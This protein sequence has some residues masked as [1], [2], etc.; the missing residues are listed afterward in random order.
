M[1]RP[2][3]KIT[4]TKENGKEYIFDYCNDIE[5][6]S[7]VKELSTKAKITLPR[8]FSFQGNVISG[9][10]DSI[11]NR[12][13]KVK[14][15]LGYY[16]NIQT[17]FEGYITTVNISIPIV[18]ECEDK[19]FLL[20]KKRINYTSREIKLEELLKNILPEEIKYKALDV[21]IGTYRIT[22]VSA[23]DVLDDLRDKLNFASYF[24]KDGVLSVGL[25]YDASYTSTQSYYFEKT[26]IDDSDLK[27]QK[28]DDLQIKVKVISI[29]RDN[30]RLEYDAGDAN[31]SMRTIYRFNVTKSDLKKIADEYLNNRKYTGYTGTFETFGEPV[32][33]PGDVCKLQ[34]EKFPE[35]NGSYLV[36][37]VVRRWGIGGYRQFIKPS[38][39]I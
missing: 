3:C 8:K 9:N 30:S 21:N 22:N 33:Y 24:R 14:I 10:G 7:G 5:I 16:P 26:I 18:I 25:P 38:A 29:N 36:D 39:K 19:M 4:F 34:S 35:R 17:M 31:G 13:D 15:E 37:S 12:G 11:F 32:I 23:Y 20:K 27:F 6:T 2:I 1:I 28:V